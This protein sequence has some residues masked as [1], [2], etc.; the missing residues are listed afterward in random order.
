MGN[1]LTIAE[2]ETTLDGFFA[3]CVDYKKRTMTLKDGKTAFLCD[4]KD[5]TDRRY[6]AERIVLPLLTAD[7]VDD[8]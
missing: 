3:A 5:L 4:F 2:L 6:I 7:R 8:L 1:G